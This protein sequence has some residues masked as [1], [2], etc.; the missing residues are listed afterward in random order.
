MECLRNGKTARTQSLSTFDL[1]SSPAKV[2]K[3]VSV[4]AFNAQATLFSSD[5]TWHGDI[6]DFTDASRP[7]KF[8]FTFSSHDSSKI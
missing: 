4:R 1:Q 3:S 2:V 8:T 5:V 7:L 6:I